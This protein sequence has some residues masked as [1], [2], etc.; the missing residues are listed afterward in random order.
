MSGFRAGLYAH[1]PKFVAISSDQPQ[2]ICFVCLTD[3][4]SC[5]EIYL[6]VTSSSDIADRLWPWELITRLAFTSICLNP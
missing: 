3:I 1:Y 6:F 2:L 4:E 5:F